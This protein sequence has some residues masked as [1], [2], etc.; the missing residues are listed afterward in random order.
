LD[1]IDTRLLIAPINIINRTAISAT[2]DNVLVGEDQVVY[3]I[4]DVVVDSSVTGVSDI[5][6]QLVY[7]LKSPDTPSLLLAEEDTELSGNYYDLVPKEIATAYNI[8]TYP[9]NGLLEVGAQNFGDLMRDK[10]VFK[11]FTYFE[12]TEYYA[13]PYDFTFDDDVFRFSSSIKPLNESSCY[14]SGHWEWSTRDTA[15]NSSREQQAYKTPKIEQITGQG[16][17]A[18]FTVNP[19]SVTIIGTAPGVLSKVAVPSI[20]PVKEVVVS[21]LRIRGKGR[22]LNLKYRNEPGKGFHLLGWA[23][24]VLLEKRP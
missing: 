7:T 22:V 23:A 11:V 10:Q 16:V 17:P 9:V 13:A 19:A 2:T 21:R 5:R 15:G 3:G 4:R 14:V 20:A 18:N 8:T 24:P 1:G 12:T 6:S